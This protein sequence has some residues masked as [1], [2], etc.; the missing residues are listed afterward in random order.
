MASRWSEREDGKLIDLIYD[1]AFDGTLWP[2]VLRE[3]ADRAGA[4]PANLL[5][6]DVVDG[7]GFGLT[8]R[9][10]EDTVS[11]FFDEWAQRNLIGLVQDAG[12]YHA[13]WTP[14]ITHDSECVDRRLLER[15]DYW[16]EFLVPLGAFHMINMRLALRDNDVTAIGLGRPNYLGPF[17]DDEIARIKPLHRHLIR[18]ERIWRGLG[19]RQAEFDHFDA[20]LAASPEALFFL[21]DRFKLLRWTAAA[22][23]LLRDGSTLRAIE[24]RLCAAQSDGNAELQRALATALAAGA[25]LPLTLA[26]GSAGD[27]V[28]VSVARMGERVAAGV[29][30]ARCLMV[31]VRSLAAP[32]AA[33]ALRKSYDLTVAEAELALALSAG[34]SLRDVAARRGVSIHTV[35]NQLGA[36]FDK[37]GCRRQQDLV[38][39][40]TTQRA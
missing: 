1:T 25:P 9:T 39:L 22:D 31:S 19:L 21:D 26:G 35:R 11:C 12:D 8:A 38:R 7:H 32:D 34:H 37:T 16:N 36:V 2:S 17:A 24:G 14:R 28:V 40:L 15:S 6:I 13:G 27:A 3:V 30:G 4:H 29:S 23:A 18:A 33:G 10:P 20:L 5:Q